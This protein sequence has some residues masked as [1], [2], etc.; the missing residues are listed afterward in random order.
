MKIPEVIMHYNIQDDRY[1]IYIG[2]HYYDD[3]QDQEIAFGL[4]KEVVNI[5]KEK[6][7][8]G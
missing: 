6:Y 4:Y 7:K 3:A 1:Y 8:E 5:V 2:E